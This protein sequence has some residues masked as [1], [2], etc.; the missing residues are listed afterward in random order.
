MHSVQP[1][2]SYIR[3]EPGTR[4]IID[5]REKVAISRH[6]NT[7]AYAFPC[8]EHLRNAC[9]EVLDNPVGKAGEFYTSAIIDGM[10]LKGEEVRESSEKGDCVG[11]WRYRI[12]SPLQKIELVYTSHSEKRPMLTKTN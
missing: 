2:F 5:I 4:R 1:I 10:I 6:A 12:V 11:V 9:R 3:F 7:G 8:G